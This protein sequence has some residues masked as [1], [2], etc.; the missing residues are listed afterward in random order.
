M[1]IKRY[2][3]NADNTI[4]KCRF[5]EREDGTKGI[6]P[7]ILQELLAARKKYKKE[8]EELKSMVKV[9]KSNKPIKSQTINNNTNNTMTNSNNTTNT[10]NTPYIIPPMQSTTKCC[11]VIKQDNII[12]IGKIIVAS[13]KYGFKIK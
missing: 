12:K 3:A 1:A 5:A 2:I 7:Q 6:I 9:N 13:P 11:F 4:T 10:N 8:M